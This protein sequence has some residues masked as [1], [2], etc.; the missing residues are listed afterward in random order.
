[1]SNIDNYNYSI[2]NDYGIKLA[3][4]IESITNIIF[5]I[6][7]YIDTKYLLKDFVIP[8][9]HYL[10]NNLSIQ[11]YQWWI[12]MIAMQTCLLLVCIPSKYNNNSYT[13]GL[14]TCR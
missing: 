6:Y 14:I 7:A 13:I 4:I 8:S 11:F 5:I 12:S 10:I 3:F 1:M 2:I 9:E